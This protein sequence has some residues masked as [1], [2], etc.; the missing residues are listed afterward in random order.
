MVDL[1]FGSV[2]Y[3]LIGDHGYRHIDKGGDIEGHVLE[4]Y[5]KA[6]VTRRKG[7]NSQEGSGRVVTEC[8]TIEVWV[9]LNGDVSGLEDSASI[10]L[11]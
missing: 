10:V 8:P 5:H 7:I 11:K 1:E 9:P 6:I 2:H 4:E 3:R